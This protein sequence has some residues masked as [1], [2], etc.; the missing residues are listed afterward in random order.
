MRA[1]RRIK[2]LLS[3]AKQV[4]IFTVQRT[5][6]SE[7]AAAT[8]SR[9]VCLEETLLVAVFNQLISYDID[10]E[11]YKLPH[12]RDAAWL[13]ASQETWNHQQAGFPCLSLL[14]LPT[15]STNTASTS[16]GHLPAFAHV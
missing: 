14:A 11:R 13:V 2:H 15:F 8:N 9:Q 12:M 3:E 7:A 5:L 6:T 10:H 16:D 4:C 1:E